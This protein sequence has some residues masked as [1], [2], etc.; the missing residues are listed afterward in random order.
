MPL[1]ME[2]G[3]S[4]DD[5]VLDGDSAAP[6]MGTASP[7]FQPMAIV[8]KRSPISANAEL[9]FYSSTTCGF[10]LMVQN[11]DDDD[12]HDNNNNYYTCIII[13]IDHFSGPGRA[14]G[15]V[16]LCARTLTFEPK[17]DLG[18]RHLPAVVLHCLD[19]FRRSRSWITVRGRRR[20]RF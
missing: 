11:D 20:K 3:L 16:C 12:D 17:K 19:H 4:L 7:N 8:A 13:I 5:I 6:Q 2:V 18:P 9:L 14:I 15:P 1:G 10:M